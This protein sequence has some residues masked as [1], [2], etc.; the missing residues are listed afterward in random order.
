MRTPIL[1]EEGF[2]NPLRL[3]P[4][5]RWILLMPL[6]ERRQRPQRSSRE[7]TTPEPGCQRRQQQE[8]FLTPG[9]TYRRGRSAQTGHALGRAWPSQVRSDNKKGG[10]GALRAGSLG[11]G[12][13]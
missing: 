8:G 12:G 10:R 9:G 6:T 7:R 13:D 2:L 11:R 1:T 5:D 4:R 3:R